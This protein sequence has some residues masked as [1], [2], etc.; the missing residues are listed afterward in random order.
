[1][2]NGSTKRSS[3]LIWSCSK[4]HPTKPKTYVE[5]LMMQKPQVEKIMKTLAN[6]VVMNGGWKSEN[7]I[8]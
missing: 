3:V 8:N 4:L 6:H 5:A 7:H 1:M 2:G